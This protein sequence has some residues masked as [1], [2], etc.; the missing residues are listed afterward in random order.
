M[1]ASRNEVLFVGRDQEVD[2][3][4][5]LLKKNQASLVTCQGRRRIGKSTLIKHCSQ[6][7]DCF[8]S[9][10]G[11]PPRKDITRQHQLE[12]FARRLR[13]Q[14]QV[15]ELSL[16]DWSQAFELLDSQLPRRGRTVLLLDEISWMAYGD[17]DFSG[18]LKNAWDERFS[19]RRG[20]I[21]VLC[22]SVSSWIEDN[23]LNSTGFVGRCSWHYNLQP[24]ALPHC[25]RFWRH[26]SSR[27]PV[28][29]KLRMLCVTGGVPRY[30]EEC[31]HQLI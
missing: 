4:R 12:E 2:E 7:A 18:H 16:Q 22:G 14:T 5:Q 10:S 1:R 11:L 15:P 6:Y 31:H 30:L 27:T 29:E 25:A 8:L 17:A 19:R 13:E 21:V 20:L 23:I 3:F 28:A 26:R 24:L 9:F